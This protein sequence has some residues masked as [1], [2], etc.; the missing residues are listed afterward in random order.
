MFDFI[1]AVLRFVTSNHG[2]GK[3]LNLCVIEY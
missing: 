1:F 2:R 3:L